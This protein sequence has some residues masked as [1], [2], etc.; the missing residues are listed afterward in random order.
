MSCAKAFSCFL[1]LSLTMGLLPIH[2]SLAGSSSSPHSGLELHAP[3]DT[4]VQNTY[5]KIIA[6]DG[7]PIVNGTT[8]GD[9]DVA[10]DE[11]KSLLYGF[12]NPLTPT[13][14]FS[15]LRIKSESSTIDYRLGPRAP[16][17]GPTLDGSTIT[18]RWDLF[19]H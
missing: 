19:G 18:S 2:P 14:G 6:T 8:G 12:P 13:T 17:T 4:T 10:G 9:P 11:D 3:Q 16:S 5:I 1:A 15:T 7:G